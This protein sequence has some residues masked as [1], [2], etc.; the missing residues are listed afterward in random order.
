M[1]SQKSIKCC[2]CELDESSARNILMLNKKMPENETKGGWGCFTCHLPVKGAIAV[3]CDSCADK[4]RA[5]EPVKFACLGAPGENRR[6]S[7]EELTEDFRH[8]L[9]K[10]TEDWREAVWHFETVR[11]QYEEFADTPGVNTTIALEHVFRP[12]AERYAAG[13]RTEELFDAMMSVE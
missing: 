6:I 2:I 4:H 11:K 5:G 1:E 12:L 7:V 13:E 3:L 10:H 9:T 8:D